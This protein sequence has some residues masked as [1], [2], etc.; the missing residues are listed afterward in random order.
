MREAPS[1]VI[2]EGLLERGATVAAHDPE[3]GHAA[4]MFFGDR[5]RYA[6][7]NY[8]AIDGADALLIITEWKQYRVPDFQRMQE[9]LRQPL[10]LDGRNLYSPSRM[11]ELGFDYISVG[12]PGV[13]TRRAGSLAR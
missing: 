9:L 3:A 2:V 1:L 6:E 13:R 5:I 4:R 11:Q 7:S 10:V 8:D 12:R